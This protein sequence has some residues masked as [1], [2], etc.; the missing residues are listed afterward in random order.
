MDR[1]RRVDRGSIAFVG[2]VVIRG[3]YARD[4]MMKP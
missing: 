2:G 4:G 3:G 1:P